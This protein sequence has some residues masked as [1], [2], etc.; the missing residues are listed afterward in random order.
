MKIMLFVLLLSI[1]QCVYSQRYSAMDE[2]SLWLLSPDP[3]HVQSIF[4][5]VNNLKTDKVIELIDGVD[6]LSLSKQFLLTGVLAKYRNYDT[7]YQTCIKRPSDVERAICLS[8]LR[9]WKGERQNELTPL[10]LNNGKSILHSTEDNA[11]YIVAFYL[12]STDFYSELVFENILAVLKLNNSDDPLDTQ[13]KN[14]YSLALDSMTDSETRGFPNSFIISYYEHWLKDHKDRLKPSTEKRTDRVIFT[15]YLHGYSLNLPLSY[16]RIHDD[17]LSRGKRCFFA[18]TE[19]RSVAVD[20]Y[21]NDGG[22]RLAFE[23]IQKNSE[24]V[25]YKETM[26]SRYYPGIVYSIKVEKGHYIGLLVE[27]DGRL[28]LTTVSSPKDSD[29]VS[30][31]ENILNGLSIL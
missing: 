28:I 6:K 2:I 15:N 9:E 11:R 10:E 7:V 14:L 8:A 23:A 29:S 22:L 25:L 5:Q 16:N 26:V 27:A 13:I 21:P 19:G 24:A 12:A 4:R 1:S 17:K 31:V 3:A 18:D 20:T 30:D